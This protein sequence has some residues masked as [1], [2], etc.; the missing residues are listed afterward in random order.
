MDEAVEI[1]GEHYS[2]W[3]AED[4]SNYCEHTGFHTFEDV[5]TVRKL[6]RIYGTQAHT[7]EAINYSSS[8][9]ERAIELGEVVTCRLSGLP[10]GKELA[11]FDSWSPL[12][13]LVTASPDDMPEGFSGI[14]VT[15]SFEHQK[16][17][18]FNVHI[19]A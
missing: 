14:I 11:H 6:R 7:V 19:A 2:S 10:I 3:Y 18:T 8:A 17:F 1:D 5:I 9:L 15:R 4:N 13:R 12:P 16:E